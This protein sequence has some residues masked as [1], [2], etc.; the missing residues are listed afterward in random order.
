M[1]KHEGVDY[2]QIRKNVSK[3]FYMVLTGKM[4][5]REALLRFPRDCSDPTV[6]ACW[7]AMCHL[8]AD[9]D[10]RRTDMLYAQEQNEYIEFIADTL[11]QGD[12]LPKN[13]IN[14]YLPYH[15][16]ALIAENTTVKGIFNKLRKFL[17]C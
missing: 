10:L 15:N 14:E 17:C 12:E 7:H 4:P 11:K 13:I 5:V 8:E 2:K 3:L 1:Q 16:E 9:E 6:T